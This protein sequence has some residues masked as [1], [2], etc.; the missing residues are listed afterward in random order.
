[1]RLSERNLTPVGGIYVV[2]ALL[3]GLVLTA[4]GRSGQDSSGVS[5]PSAAS[6]SRVLQESA[7]ESDQPNE[8]SITVDVDLAHWLE[9][10]LPDGSL[11]VE[12]FPLPG[13][14]QVSLALER[15]E[16]TRADTRY[17]LG[18]IGGGD[19]ELAYDPSRLALYRGRVRGLSDS[20]VFIGFGG[21]SAFGFIDIGGGIRRYQVS[22]VANAQVPFGRT[23]LSVFQSDSVV[24]LPPN[25]A[26]C[27]VDTSGFGAAPTSSPLPLDTLPPTPRVM[28][29]AV[30]TDY[31]LFELFNDVDAVAD[32]VT[33]MYA[34]VSDIYLRDVNTRIVLTFVRVW[35]TPDDLFNEESPLSP[36]RQYW[37]AN[38]GHVPR[39]AAQFFSGRRNMP[40]GG[41]AYL[42]SL[43]GSSGYSVVGYVL[44]Y[45]PNPDAPSAF[46][47]DIPVTAHELGHNFGAL[48]THNYGIDT[49]ND[50]FGPTERGTIMSYCSQTRNGGNANTDL[51]IHAII[52]DVIREYF[53]G[54]S[55]LFHDCN[56]NGVPDDQDISRGDSA[57]VNGNGVPDECEDCN[58]NGV[59]DTLD[60]DSGFSADLNGN[61]IPDE[62]EADCNGN[63][64]PDD[65]DI[66][67]GTSQDL[68]GNN[69]P[70]ECEPD[71]NGNGVPDYNEIQADM[72]LDVDRNIVL[73]SCQDCDDDGINDLDA[74]GGAHNVWIA[75]YDPRGEAKEFH[76]VSGALV[77]ASEWGIINNGNDL[78]I[79]ADGRIL[80][81]SSAD[82]RVVQLNAA[83]EHVGDFVEAGSG[84]LSHPA[85]MTF[86]PD[87]D[88]FVV[89]HN[90]DSVL[91][92]DGLTG[93]SLGEFVTEG[94]GELSLPFGLAF[95]PDGN[96]YV[97]S[98]SG[99][100][101]ILRYD[102]AT[103]QFI[104]VFVEELDNGGLNDPR[105]LLFKPDGNLLVASFATKQV[106]EYDGQTGAFVRQFNNGGT[107]TALTLD[108][109]WALRLGRTGNVFVSRHVI[110]RP[111]VGDEGLGARILNLHLNTTRIFEFDVDTGIFLRSYV[112][113]HD[114]DLWTP[115]GFD[116]MP[117]FD[118]DCNF[119]MIPDSCDIAD[120]R[121]LDKNNNGIPDEC[122]TPRIPGDIDG[123]GSVGVSDL[124]VLLANWGLCADCN[125]CPADIDGDCSVG[126]ADLFILLANWG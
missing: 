4:D 71:C 117:G 78:I 25:V 96:L 38:M 44:G 55:C 61:D 111:N 18:R 99:R 91:R 19:A 113:G 31:E 28:E 24:S 3:G 57:D 89:S 56:D 120:G 7:L 16:V 90:N 27:G 52:K 15:F 37:N 98:R 32:Y 54:I 85:A 10:T 64:V 95:G 17:V 74:L 13:G 40:Y 45:F 86:G 102:G 67:L 83:G 119:N 94:S 114:T 116:F 2:A 30:E 123:D 122:E 43:C 1:M 47:Y 14:V 5:T 82:D 110:R 87:G 92:Y 51:R 125:N 80:I 39:D 36:F 76:A 12:Q 75:N 72:T 6:S 97:S 69:I 49:C 93:A 115:T 63:V 53:D 101:T 33:L 9:T 70:D 35:D 8:D 60:I 77:K 84:G 62:C 104:D 23:S 73:D 46:H 106:L 79:S 22:A 66:F 126:V 107:Q 124:L 21:G 20:H 34:A 65:W 41:A 42:S 68:N 81:T 59:I 50:L 112:M 88:L 26:L 29:L 121:S 118:S 109:P 103:G 100:G 11:V 105:G 108:G 58:G 48:H